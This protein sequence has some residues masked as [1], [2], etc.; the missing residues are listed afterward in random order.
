MVHHYKQYPVV[1]STEEE[2]SGGRICQ[3]RRKSPRVKFLRMWQAQLKK[4]KE[5]QET[6]LHLVKLK[7]SLIRNTKKMMSTAAEADT[8][9]KS[10]DDISN[11]PKQ[12]KLRPGY[13]ALQHSSLELNISHNYK[14]YH[15]KAGE[16]LR[17]YDV[18]MDCQIHSNIQILI[19][20]SQKAVPLIG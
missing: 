4:K 18:M 17:S 19:F 5:K 20:I 10:L 1:R 16:F 6:P 2:S 3:K 8:R 7:L 9:H 11:S 14:H 15:N 13:M 12:E